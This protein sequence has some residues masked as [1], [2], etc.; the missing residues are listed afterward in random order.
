MKK[1]KL[2]D[3]LLQS[4]IEFKETLPLFYFK[5]MTEI[6][7]K[8]KEYKRIRRKILSLLPEEIL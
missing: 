7:E 1:R 8:E 4:Y 3:L 2:L 6:R 5:S